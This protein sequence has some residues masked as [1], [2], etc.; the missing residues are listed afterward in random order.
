MKECKSSQVQVA[1]E[2]T[3][4][5]THENDTI[6]IKSNSLRWCTGSDK[7]RRKESEKDSREAE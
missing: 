6:F 1:E 7:Q 4:E 5:W 3:F 2:W